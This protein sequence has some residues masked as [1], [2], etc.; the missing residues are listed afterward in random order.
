MLTQQQALDLFEY[1]KGKLFWRINVSPR[2]RAGAEAG[3]PSSSGHIKIRYLHKY[4]LAHRIVFIMFNKNLP[5]CIDHINGD[6]SDN[7]I[8]NLRAATPSQNAMNKKLNCT[9]RS[10]AKNVRWSA[11]RS[12]W[13][14]QM[15]IR[16]KHTHIGTFEDFE[17]AKFV[18]AE[19]RDKYHG[20][21]ANH[22]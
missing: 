18:A 13:H 20:E 2:A 6:P 4:Y 14:V 22:G 11:E 16:G 17:L 12:K 7:R 10:K 15:S 5:D 1:E 9:S 19:Y 3:S 8:E 21:F